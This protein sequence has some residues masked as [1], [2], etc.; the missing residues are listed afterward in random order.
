[1]IKKVLFLC[2]NNSARSQMAEAFLRK[3]G[4]ENYQVFSAGKDPK[5][6]HPL[7]VKVMDEVG[8]DISQQ[9]SKGMKELMGRMTF[10]DA[11]IVCRRAEDDCPILSADAHRIH[12]WL[13]EDPVRV[14]GSDE[15]K[16]VAFRSVRDQIE[17]RIQLWL[18][19]T[20]EAQRQ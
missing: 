8:V 14:D 17:A 10:D 11:I 19:E 18:A 6:V 13:F 9:R 7:T 15:E 5:G 4:G 2:T 12:R 16:L 20:L 1:M 3:H